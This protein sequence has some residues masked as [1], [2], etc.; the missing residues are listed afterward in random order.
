MWLGLL[1]GRANRPGSMGFRNFDCKNVSASD[2]PQQLGGYRA[3]KLEI[4]RKYRHHPRT[5][6]AVTAL[7]EAASKFVLLLFERVHVGQSVGL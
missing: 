7:T 3:W 4:C 1:G 2:N 6:S 5:S